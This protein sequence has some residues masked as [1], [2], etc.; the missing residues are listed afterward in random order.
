MKLAVE[1]TPFKRK[2]RTTSLKIG[3]PSFKGLTQ[4]LSPS[5]ASLLPQIATKN[6][7]N[8]NSTCLRK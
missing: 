6:F 8:L 7:L 5:F 2:K 4:T 3:P 1:Q